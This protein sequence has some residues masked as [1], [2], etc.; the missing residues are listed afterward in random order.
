MYSPAAHFWSSGWYTESRSKLWASPPC[1]GSASMHSVRKSYRERNAD[2]PSA[3][4]G[5]PEKRNRT[6]REECAGLDSLR[7]CG[8]AGS[9]ETGGR[10]S[11]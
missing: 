9:D 4:L 6:L 10:A 8:G 3:R 1:A 2:R 7:R 11:A 5:G